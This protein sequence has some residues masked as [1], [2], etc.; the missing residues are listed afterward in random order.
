MT[1]FLQAHWVDIGALLA[2]AHMLLGVMGNFGL[3]VQGI[4][5][6]ITNIIKALGFQSQTPP[7]V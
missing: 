4:D 3:K 7:K 2:I 5:D 1:S 6:V